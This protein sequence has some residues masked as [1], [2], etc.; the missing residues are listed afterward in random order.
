MTLYKTVY[1]YGVANAEAFKDLITSSEVE[2]V[3]V[4]RIYVY[5]ITPTR[6]A[7]GELRLYIE[8]EKIAEIPLMLYIDNLTTKNY[9]A[10]PVYEVNADIPVGQTLIA[11]LVSGA[12][13]TNLVVVLEYEITA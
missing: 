8:R 7:N 3:R 1:I 13:A 10:Q 2:P 11:G 4:K 6:Q 9:V 5:E 12:T